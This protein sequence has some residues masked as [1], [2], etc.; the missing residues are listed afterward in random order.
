MA[1]QKAKKAAKIA[2][3][4]PNMPMRQVMKK[5]GYSQATA[6]HP[7]DLTESKGWQELMEE[8]LPDKHLAEMHKQFLDSPRIITRYVK[9][10]IVDEYEE[11]SPQAVKALDMAY[12]LKKRYSDTNINGVMIVNLSPAAASKYGIQSN[13]IPPKSSLEG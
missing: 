3:E 10:E 9:G 6:D 5:A 4:N 13:E 12:K 11:T 1:T 7:K 2:L 8:Y